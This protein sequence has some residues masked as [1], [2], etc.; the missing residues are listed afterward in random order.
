MSAAFFQ[1]LSIFAE[2]YV[3]WLQRS[4]NDINLEEH[5]I[6]NNQWKYEAE[7]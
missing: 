4:I 5:L 3:F 1:H 2:I 6:P 7:I